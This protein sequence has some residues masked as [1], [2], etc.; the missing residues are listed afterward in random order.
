MLNGSCQH[1]VEEC[2]SDVSSVEL[3]AEFV[4]IALKIFR[5]YVMKDVEYRSLC[6]ADCYMHP[7]KYLSN[8][9]FWYH[10]R[11]VFLEHFVK[12]GVG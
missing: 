3:E 4:Q 11:V 1:A 2:F 10:L 7:R 6:I 12:V 8:Q 9:F 5:L